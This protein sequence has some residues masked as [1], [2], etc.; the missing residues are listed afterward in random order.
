MINR[1]IIIIHYSTSIKKYKR[2]LN[3]TY[4]N[5][6]HSMLNQKMKNINKIDGNLTQ[7]QSYNYK[8][9]QENISW[10]LFEKYVS[11]IAM[12]LLTKS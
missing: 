9:L 3:N 5:S 7:T 10:Q 11:L 1:I 12:Y 6:K 2:T 8:Y 4:G